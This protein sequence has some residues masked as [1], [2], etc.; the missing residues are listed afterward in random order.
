MGSDEIPDRC[1]YCGSRA[2]A[3]HLEFCQL[4]GLTIPEQGKMRRK[5]SLSPRTLRNS[6][7]AT[8]EERT[9]AG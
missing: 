9:A 5:L 2:F 8:S 1:E 7:S 4:L 6:A 3:A